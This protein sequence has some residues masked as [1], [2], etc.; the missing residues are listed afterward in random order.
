MSVH[1]RLVAASLALSVLIGCSASEE[2]ITRWEKYDLQG[3]ALPVQ[4]GPWACVHDHHT[5]LRWEA[6]SDN[7]GM[8][9]AGSTYYWKM[10]APVY[11][12]GCMLQPGQSSACDIDMLIDHLRRTRRC[13]RDDW[14]LPRVAE[15]ETLLYDTG[16]PG[17]ARTVIGFFPH[18]GRAAFWTADTGTDQRGRDAAMM[19]HF[20]TGEKQWLPLDQVAR[21][22]LVSGP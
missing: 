6:K 22:R 4:D 11:D 20:G 13:G 18:G 21:V 1:C 3:N 8:S 12:G 5:G 16:F 14:R 9:Y 7:E 17:H 10:E 15:L 2:P 19:L